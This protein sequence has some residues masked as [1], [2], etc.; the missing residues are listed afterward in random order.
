VPTLRGSALV[1]LLPWLAL[2][3]VKDGV[4]F[5]CARRAVFAVGGVLAALAP[6]GSLD[7]RQPVNVTSCGGLVACEDD[8]LLDARRCRAGVAALSFVEP[9]GVVCLSRVLEPG[10][11]DVDPC[12]EVGEEGLSVELFCAPSATLHARRMAVATD[13]DMRFMTY[14]LVKTLPFDD[15]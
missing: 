7:W 1:G 12:D 10:V 2:E 3:R 5:A 4:A 13:I 15:R 8:G 11:C 14:L 6:D 9:L